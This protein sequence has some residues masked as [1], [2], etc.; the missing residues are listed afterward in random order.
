MNK[1]LDFF[2]DNYIF[3]FIFL[4][5]SFIILYIYPERWY[6]DNMWEYGM[7]HSIKMGDI[8]YKDFNT[9]TTPLFIFI[10]SLFLYIKDEFY[11]SLLFISLIITVISY[12][13]KLLVKDKWFILFIAF[14]FPS[15]SLF[16]GSYNL[17]TFMLFL[18]LLYFEKEKF[19]DRL[20]GLLLG[21][22]ILSKHTVGLGILFISFIYIFDFKRIFKR[23]LFAFIPIFIFIIYLVITK[24][25]YQFI[26]LTF[27]GLFDFG[28]NNTKKPL[29]LVIPILVMTLMIIIKTIIS[30]N[31]FNLYYLVGLLFLTPI[32]DF[33]HFYYFPLFILFLLDNY[34]FNYSKYKI[35]FIVIFISLFLDNYKEVRL[36][37]LN[38]DTVV[39]YN[40]HFKYIIMEKN[41][42]N[43]S[44]LVLDKY[45]K[46]K[47]RIM[48]TGKGMYYDISTDNKITYFSIPLKGNFGYNGDRKIQNKFD[49]LEDTYIF[50]NENVKYLKQFD[51]DLVKYIKENSVKVEEFLDYEIYYKK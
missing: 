13:F 23:S 19:D 29:I 42:Y 5:V 47:N 24:S 26:D 31:K 1:I 9:V 12:I 36:K 15:F 35:I 22:I 43:D 41:R 48:V 27:L 50:I 51:K 6:Y 2:K 4:F 34:K 33:S 8:P 39:G 25:F 21:L 38:L 7:A 17:F 49:D 30:K 46:Y 3:L 37:Y 10:M 16:I 40:N 28:I 18:L 44:K 20:I 14:C 32:I 45:K 11:I